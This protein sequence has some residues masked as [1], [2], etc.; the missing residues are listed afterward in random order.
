MT[1]DDDHNSDDDAVGYG[2][3]PKHSRFQPGRSGNP[4]GRPRRRSTQLPDLIRAELDQTLTLKEGGRER[5]VTKREAIVKQLVALAIKGN[6]K[7]LQLILAHLEKHRDVDPFVATA[8][9]DAELLRALAGIGDRGG[10]NDG[11]H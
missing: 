11:D 1:S 2:R 4:R 6:T 7:P 8:E 9:D 10:K 3:P 5:R